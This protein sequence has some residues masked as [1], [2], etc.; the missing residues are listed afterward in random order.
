MIDPRSRYTGLPDKLD[1]A[2]DGTEYVYRARRLPPLGSSLDVRVHM[3]P[4][5]DE[6]LDVFTARALSDPRL[7]WRIADANDALDPDQM[8]REGAPLAIP[9][10]MVKVK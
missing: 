9:T 2:E 5:P 7:F 10:A 8:M 6:R 3:T 4:E 1:R